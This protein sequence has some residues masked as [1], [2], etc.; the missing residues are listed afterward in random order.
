MGEGV[1]RAK[2][3]DTYVHGIVFVKLG[4]LLDFAEQNKDGGYTTEDLITGALVS[5]P[6]IDEMIDALLEELGIDLDVGHLDR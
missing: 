3:A 1:A 6:S 4:V 5:L 2:M